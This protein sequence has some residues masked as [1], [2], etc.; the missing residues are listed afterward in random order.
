M[1]NRI[2]TM[3]RAGRE[4]LDW[5][6]ERRSEIFCLGEDVYNFGGIF[7]TMDGFGAKYGPERVINTPI[8]ETGFI[9]MAAGAAMAGMHPV[10]DLAYIDFIGVC[11][12]V[13]LN[14]ASKTHYMSGGA[15][16]CPMTLLIG[17]GGGYNNAAQHSQCLHATVAHI[18]GVKVVYPSNAYDAKGMLH[19]ALRDENFVIFLTHKGTAGVGFMGTPIKST[20]SEVPVDDYTVPFGKVKVYREGSDVTLVGLGMSVHES[21]KAAEDLEKEGVS[22]QVVDLRSLVPLD[23]DGLAEAVGK[24]G[25]LVVADE[26]YMS[27]GVSGEVIASV[28][29]RLGKP[30][31][32][33]RVCMPDIPIPFSRPMEQAILP[34]SGRIADAARSLM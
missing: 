25:R 26:D 3:A 9:G 19:T 1:S 17:T 2:L 22:A 28:A 23:R 12:N 14:T 7:G 33:A 15:V 8:S 31:K 24:T 34:L 29:E 21:L 30:F 10:I 27:Y 13:L 20:L 16:K 5:E 32:V 18:P 6:M 4:A 11:Y